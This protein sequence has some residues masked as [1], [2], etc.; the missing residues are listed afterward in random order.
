L[1]K[2]IIVLAAIIATNCAFAQQKIGYLNSTEILQSMPE[3]KTMSESI[4]KKKG[5]YSKMMESMYAEYDKKTKELQA[6]PNMSKPLQDTKM[7]ELK[8]LEKRMN[9]FQQ[10]AQGDLQAYAQE[11][12]KPL[13]AKYQN[14]VKEVSKEQ[15]FSYVLDLATN[16]VVYYPETGGFDLSPAVKTKLGAN[17]SAPKPAAPK[18]ATPRPAGK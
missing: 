11:I 15:G 13:Q 16:S 2:L 18:P 3:Y 4:E 5:E 10:K 1:K 12:A 7:Q 8:D 17:M 6:D 14:A 9:D